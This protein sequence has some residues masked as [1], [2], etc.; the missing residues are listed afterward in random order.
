MKNQPN[1]IIDILE[2]TLTAEGEHIARLA[3]YRAV[4]EAEAGEG[5]K[6]YVA[7]TLALDTGEVETRLYPGRVQYFMGAIARQTHGAVVGM[8]LSQILEYLKAHDFSV[9]A[10]WDEEYGRMQY[11]FADH[12]Q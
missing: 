12:R 7:L 11:D 6:P 3:K 1:S 9:W 2:S 8:K 4:T 5:K 10:S